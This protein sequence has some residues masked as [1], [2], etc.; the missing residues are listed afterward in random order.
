MKQ[1]YKAIA[2]KNSPTKTSV[3]Q[4]ETK[5]KVDNLTDMSKFSVVENDPDNFNENMCNILSSEE[6]ET[7]WHNIKL[8]DGIE[9]KHAF[10][11]YKPNDTL[12]MNKNHINHDYS[13]IEPED[14]SLNNQS[15][16]IISDD[17]NQPLDILEDDYVEVNNLYSEEEH[18]LIRDLIEEM[19]LSL[20]ENFSQY[21][22]IN[23]TDFENILSTL[24][25]DYFDYLENNNSESFINQPQFEDMM[26]SA[27]SELTE[28]SFVSNVLNSS[29]N[30]NTSNDNFEEATVHPN[31]LSAMEI[32]KHLGS[33]NKEKSG[34]NDLF[35]ELIIS[36]NHQ[37]QS[38]DFQISNNSDYADTASFN[39]S[40]EE[41]RGAGK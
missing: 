33:E 12:N 30:I 16:L 21:D 38:K 7:L 18:A 6:N 37:L 20:G 10:E 24:V 40:I 4:L 5:L 35:L 14:K 41:I 3:K 8:E 26:V 32:Q 29:Q 31:D 1:L 27:L 15:D 39:D 13:V 2:S 36:L 19:E 22:E 25:F 23:S 28:D 17:A 34:E 11:D 9:T